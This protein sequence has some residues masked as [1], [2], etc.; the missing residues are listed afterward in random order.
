[1]YVPNDKLVCITD[2]RN[3]EHLMIHANCN[4]NKIIYTDISNRR[5]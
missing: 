3:T 1:M 4:N 5:S 2:E